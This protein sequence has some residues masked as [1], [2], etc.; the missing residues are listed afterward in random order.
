MCFVAWFQFSSS[1]AFPLLFVIFRKSNLESLRF[2]YAKP[3]V[4]LSQL[5]LRNGIKNKSISS[6][7]YQVC[8]IL[9][10]SHIAILNLVLRQKKLLRKTLFRSTWH[11]ENLS[12][13][14]TSN[15]EN[16]LRSGV[17][18]DVANVNVF[19]TSRRALNYSTNFKFLKSSSRFVKSLNLHQARESS[20][21]VGDVQL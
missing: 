16:H 3:H 14:E 6:S 9:R 11:D 7:R 10:D 18:L 12:G 5:R 4:K 2:R 21:V 20:R 8:I 17:S 1:I 15:S 13:R 19:A